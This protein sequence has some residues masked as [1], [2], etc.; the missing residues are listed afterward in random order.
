MACCC[1]IRRVNAMSQSCAIRVAS[2]LP[3][4]DVLSELPGTYVP[5]HTSVPF[6]PAAVSI[7]TDHKLD[8]V[9][10]LICAPPL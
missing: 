2:F 7:R 6:L 4:R 5:H 1:D 3:S 10:V 8:I 9:V